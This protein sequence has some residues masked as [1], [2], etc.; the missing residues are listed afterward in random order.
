MPSEDTKILEFNQYHK[1]DRTPFVFYADLECVIEKVHGYRNN[2]GKPSTRKV[3]EH[4]LSG[5]SMSV[6]I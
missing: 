6:L 2:P 1:S 5:F 3:G 4:I